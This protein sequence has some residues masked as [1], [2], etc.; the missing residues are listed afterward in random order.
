MSAGRHVCAAP[1][2]AESRKSTAGQLRKGPM[3]RIAPALVSLLSAC[4]VVTQHNDT[5][6]TGANLHERNLTPAAVQTR[7]MQLSYW[8]PVT[9]SMRTQP[10]Y[11]SNLWSDYQW[12]DVIYAATEANWIYAYDAGNKG[13]SGTNQG[14]LWSRHLPV[15]ANLSLAS[16]G[17]IG[18][19][20]VIDPSSNTMYVVY[21][22]NNGMLPPNGWGDGTFAA[23]FHLVA[24]DIKTGNVLRDSV[25]RGSVTS[26]V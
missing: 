24:L 17:G 11:V 26:P 14:L 4:Q 25:I 6:R 18:G 2:G 9:G 1:N 5:M 12:R 22:I 10:L 23:E 15:N 16:D 7:G 3:R 21:G 13:G 19:T 8:R 20:P